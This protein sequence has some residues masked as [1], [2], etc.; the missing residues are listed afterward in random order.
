MKEPR[1][2]CLVRLLLLAHDAV[3]P[4][5]QKVVGT[6]LDFGGNCGEPQCPTVVKQDRTDGIRGF[7]PARRRT[8]PDSHAELSESRAEGR[9]F[10]RS[11][12]T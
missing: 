6:F 10:A 9:A 1:S 2:G 11:H 12:V 8:R 3:Y 7:L 5:P 4:T